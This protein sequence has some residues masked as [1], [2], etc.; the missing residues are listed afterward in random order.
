MVPNVLSGFGKSGALITLT[1]VMPDLSDCVKCA[2]LAAHP[3][4]VR[5]RAALRPVFENK[6]SIAETGSVRQG[7]F[8]MLTQPYIKPYNQ[9]ST[10]ICIS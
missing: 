2:S 6:A 4:E 5:Y 7:F 1:S 9:V 8:G 10:N 3:I